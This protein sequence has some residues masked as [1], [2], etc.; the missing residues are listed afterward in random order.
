MRCSNAKGKCPNN[1]TEVEVL[2][3]LSP[4]ITSL[5]I[6]QAEAEQICDELNKDYNDARELRERRKE[7]LRSEYQKLLRRKDL[8]Y[9]DKLDGRITP[10]KYDELVEKGEKRMLEIDEELVA[11]EKSYEGSEL[12][13]SNLFKLACKADE[14]LKSSKP[15]IKNQ[16]LRLLLSNCEIQQKRLQ[17][18]LLE[19]FTFIKKLD[20]RPKWLPRS[21]SNWQPRS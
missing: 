5:S 4:V 12:T 2:E 19:P 1:A 10:E 18:N 15:A 20:S 7:A 13:V 11:L 9:E 6:N 14:L 16:I 21:D 3:Q 17:F 8:M